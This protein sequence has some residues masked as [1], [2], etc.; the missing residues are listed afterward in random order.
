MHIAALNLGSRSIEKG[1]DELFFRM[2]PE[3]LSQ[4]SARQDDPGRQP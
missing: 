4:P 1:K 3:H 2:A